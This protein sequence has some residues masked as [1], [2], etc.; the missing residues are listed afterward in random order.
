MITTA[1]VVRMMPEGIDACCVINANYAKVV[2]ALDR[3]LK[4]RYAHA[5]SCKR[6]VSDM[7]ALA[8]NLLPPHYYYP[9]T[10]SSEAVGS[11]WVMVKNAVVEA[12]ERVMEQPRHGSSEEQ[13]AV[14]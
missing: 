12:I 14:L 7:A 9:D 11:P 5:C 1:E 10:E 8:L 4:E 2:S 13:G 3:F 6:C